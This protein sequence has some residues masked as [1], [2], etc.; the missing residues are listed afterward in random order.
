MQLLLQVTLTSTRKPS[1]G[2]RNSVPDDIP[3]RLAVTFAPS[4]Y[5]SST[6]STSS[7]PHHHCYGPQHHHHHH[8]HHHLSCITF[9]L[10]RARVLQGVHANFPRR[11]KASD[12]LFVMANH[13]QLLEYSLDPV[14]DQSKISILLKIHFLTFFLLQRLQRTRCASQVQST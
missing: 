13:G 10:S 14:P 3:I 7:H 11:P 8:H 12:S 4:R 6:S 5:T 1:H 9:T 2:K